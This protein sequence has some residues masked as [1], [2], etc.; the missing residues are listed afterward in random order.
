[1]PCTVLMSSPF[2]RDRTANV[3]RR[4]CTR[5]EG[6]P[7]A[8]TTFLKWY[9][10]EVCEMLLPS[11]VVNT[12]AVFRSSAVCHPCHISPDLSRCA[13]CSLYCLSSSPMTNGAG[14][15]VRDLPFLVGASVAPPSA[16]RRFWSCLHTFNVPDLKSMLSHVRPSASDSRRPVNRMTFRM[17]S[18]SS[19]DDSRRKSFTCSSV[20]GA[21]YFFSTRGSVTR[22]AGLMRR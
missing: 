21:S 22:S 11:G 16:S 8:S 1:M 10:S 19:L 5:Q 2:W 15:N 4:S 18:R 13:A 14:F 12:R 3:W 20:S 17:I 9:R 7:I 6:T